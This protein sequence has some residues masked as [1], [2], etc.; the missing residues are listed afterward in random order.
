MLTLHV[1]RTG[2]VRLCDTLDSVH[3]SPILGLFAVIISTYETKRPYEQ[4][5]NSYEQNRSS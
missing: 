4:N 1:N 3:S 2:N 5:S